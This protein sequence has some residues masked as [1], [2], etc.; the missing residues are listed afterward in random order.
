MKLRLECP[1]VIHNRMVF[2]HHSFGLARRAGSVEHV[3][4]AVRGRTV[5]QLFARC[6]Q[7]PAVI[8]VDYELNT[9][10]LHHVVDAFLRQG[11]FG[12]NVSRTA[13]QHG[14]H[15]PYLFGTVAHH[16]SDIFRLRVNEFSENA[17]GHR[18]ELRVTYGTVFLYD[19]GSVGSHADDFLETGIDGIALH[20]YPSIK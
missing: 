13:L 1:G 4:H 16:D 19:G 8:V 7:V 6:L 11:G 12:G 15:R 17:V 5:R 20:V 14:E 3:R 9:R 2:D 18:V 10:G